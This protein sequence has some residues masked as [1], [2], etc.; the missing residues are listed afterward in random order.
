MLSVTV[1]DVYGFSI[2]TSISRAWAFGAAAFIIL[3]PLYQEVRKLKH[4]NLFS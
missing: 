4:L 2:W 1:L 3:V